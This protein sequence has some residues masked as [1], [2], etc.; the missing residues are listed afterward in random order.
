MATEGAMKKEEVVIQH[1]KLSNRIEIMNIVGGK[2]KESSSKKILYLNTIFGETIG[3]AQDSD[4]KDLRIA[5]RYAKKCHEISNPGCIDDGIEFVRRASKKYLCNLEERKTIAQLTGTQTMK[6]I[7]ASLELFRRWIE[8]ISDYVELAAS[9]DG[10]LYT[11]GINSAI[12]PG[13]TSIVSPYILSHAPF[14]GPIVTRA[15]SRAP[16]AA[17][18]FVKAL[19]EE[20]FEGVQFLTWSSETKPQL[21]SHLIR[22]ATNAGKA[23]F[24]GSDETLKTVLRSDLNLNG[25]VLQYGTGNSKIIVTSTADI[26]LAGKS[27]AEGASANTGNLC[28]CTKAAFVADDVYESFIAELEMWSEKLKAGDPTKPFNDLVFIG[29]HDIENIIVPVLWEHGIAKEEREK[30]ID[31]PYMRMIPLETCIN[32]PLVKEEYPYPIVAVIRCRD[33]M[34]AIKMAN[35]VLTTGKRTLNL[36]IFT[37]EDDL[38]YAK[39]SYL[40]LINAH[41]VLF[42][43]PTI[44]M[45]FWSH[46]GRDIRDMMRKIV[47]T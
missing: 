25:N 13:N 1:D 32:S 43:K 10:V 40:P 15:D 11:R 5:F 3:V 24:F 8:K 39:A 46:Q 23:I 42:N 41:S 36:S 6:Y 35:S 19:C 47:F 18:K 33:A 28:T 7:D 34:D 29:K 27:C 22:D 9:R 26:K 4:E 16:F 14:I 31:G 21:A 38:A 2:Q 12:L 17:Y 30:Y 45:N 20:G 44:Y 37:G